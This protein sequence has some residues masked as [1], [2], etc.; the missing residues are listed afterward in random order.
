MCV[1]CRCVISQEEKEAADVFEE[2]VS[3]FEGSKKGGGKTFVRGGI[4]NATKGKES[5]VTL[6][7]SSVGISRFNSLQNILC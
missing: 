6:C 3:S 1:E 5:I 4:V 2:F 7:L